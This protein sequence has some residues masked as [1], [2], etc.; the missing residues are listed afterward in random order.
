MGERWPTVARAMWNARRGGRA[1]AAVEVWSAGV[2]SARV[3][4]VPVWSVPVWSVPVR[5]VGVCAAAGTRSGEWAG[6][7]AGGQAGVGRSASGKVEVGGF[8]VVSGL[9]GSLVGGCDD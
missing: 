4:S 7:F 9:S 1:T 6:G 2:R 5:S 8:A 3:R